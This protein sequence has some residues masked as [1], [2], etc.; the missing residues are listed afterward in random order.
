MR[1]RNVIFRIIFIMIMKKMKIFLGRVI[2]LQ[3]I[4]VVVVVI[5]IIIIIIIIGFTALGGP[6]LPQENVASN[7]YP[8]HPPP[9][10]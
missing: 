10:L 6:S 3:I 8:R 7:F 4:I 9:N 2:F 1:D 5:I